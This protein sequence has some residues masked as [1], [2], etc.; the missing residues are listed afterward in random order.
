MGGTIERAEPDRA[1]GQSIDGRL[2][3]AT[4]FV[5]GGAGRLALRGGARA[6]LT[7]TQN[8]IDNL[9]G[10]HRWS[11]TSALLIAHS[12]T[13]DKHYAYAL[14]EDGS[15]ALPIGAPTESGSRVDLG[16]N[17][18]A[19][20]W[21]HA[22]ELFET[23]FVADATDASRQTL[24]ALKLTGGSLTVASVQADLDGDTT[25]GDMKPAG[26]FEYGSVLFAYGWEDETVGA[27]P[28]ILRHS[29]LG[30]DPAD[31]IGW[32]PDA[33]ATIG[34]QGEPI[35]AGVKGQDI[36]LVAKYAELFRIFGDPE[37]NPGWQFNVQPVQA[38]LRL[39]AVNQH[40][41][42]HEADRWWGIGRDGPWLFDGQ[43]GESLVGTRRERWG[44][45]G[46]LSAAFVQPHPRRGAVVFGFP[47]P[48]SLIA[49]TRASRLWVFDTE[50]GRWAPDFTMPSRFYSIAAVA[51]TGVALDNIPDT[52]TQLTDA[53]HRELTAL[54][55]DF[56]PGDTSAQTEVW[57]KP[58]GGS[59]ALLAT[60]PAGVRGFRLTGLTANTSY[61]VKIRH[62]KGEAL[63]EF[64]TEVAA[65]TELAPP[66]VSGILGQYV[67][68]VLPTTGL[69][70]YYET[71]DSYAGGN[72][73]GT[74]ENISGLSYAL[75]IGRAG[76]VVA[77]A[78]SQPHLTLQLA[79]LNTLRTSPLLTVRDA[80]HIVDFGGDRS[81]VAV[82]QQMDADAYAE[83]SIEVLVSERIAALWAARGGYVIVEYRTF[84]SVG[85]YT[86]AATLAYATH[87]HV[88][89]TGLT[90]SG[91]YEVRA[92]LYSTE[93]GLEATT[94]PVVMFTKITAPTATIATAGAGTPVTNI[95]VTPP[96]GLTGFDTLIRSAGGAYDALYSGVAST[97][98]TYQSTVGTCAVPDRYWVRARHTSWPEGFQHSAPVELEIVNPCVIG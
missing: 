49:G 16:W 80:Q 58:S 90:A 42:C 25:D 10:I 95:T 17:V 77:G 70:L 36:A 13:N 83:T 35:R 6:A 5:H 15:L 63:T 52:L 47:E 59:F 98:T 32:D 12:S 55:F 68:V 41:L 40:A 26:V 9:V 51:Q 48:A 45:V 85:D 62:R 76:D 1:T 54:S 50:S 2:R 67:D 88:T 44:Q 22:A 96:A 24:K 37:A 97:P 18:A 23:L 64:G 61:T 30:Q 14:A 39:G 79:L 11:P 65:S 94:T 31:S 53:P 28:H 87:A 73:Y 8:A 27:A 89:I 3:A 72:G 29:L 7:L 60:V 43:K 19:P 66:R 71:L 86:V 46:D 21:P 33:F 81:A 84:G 78:G 34:S 56:I 38:S 20:H 4:N 57:A 92:R 75:D 82:S 91:R 93:V 74:V 69:D